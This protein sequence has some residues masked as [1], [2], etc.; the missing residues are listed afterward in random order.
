MIGY[1]VHRMMLM[2]PTLIGISLITFIIIQL[3][4]GDFLSTM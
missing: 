4:P 1:I 3:P 2:V